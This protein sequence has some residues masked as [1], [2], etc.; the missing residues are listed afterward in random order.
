MASYLSGDDLESE[1][2]DTDSNK[3]K[4]EKSTETSPKKQQTTTPKEQPSPTP[5]PTP[6]NIQ[7]LTVDDLPK[8]DYVPKSSATPFKRRF[9]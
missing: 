9:K 8:S 1:T 3:E 5:R 6:K 4:H 2:G 7:E